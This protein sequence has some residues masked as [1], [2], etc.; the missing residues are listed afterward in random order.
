M[1]KLFSEEVEVTSTNSDHNTL[2]VER[3]EEVFFGVYEFEINNE[4]VIA[5]KVGEY[6]GNPVITVP[7]VEAD[8]NK[9]EAMFILKKGKQQVFYGKEQET[10]L[11]EEKVERPAGKPEI[12]LPSIFFVEDFEE[13][14]FGIYEF[15]LNGSK[16]IAEKIDTSEEGFP[17]VEVPVANGI[18]QVVLKKKQVVVEDKVKE[19]ET[20]LSE[21]FD[22]PTDN[23]FYVEEY[24]EI[25]FGVYEFELNN[26]KVLA[27]KIEEINGNP[28]VEVPVGDTKTKIVL[29][30]KVDTKNLKEDNTG[31]LNK[32]DIVNLEQYE[33]QDVV[34]EKTEADISKEEIVEKANKVKT[35]VKEELLQEFKA[36]SK[37]V[38]GQFRE[39][40]KHVVDEVER[41]RDQIFLEFASNSDNYRKDEAKKLRKFVNTRVEELREQNSGLAEKLVKNFRSNLEETYGS[42]IL[43]LRNT[44]TEL[45]A[46]K[47]EN[48]KLA[49][50][51]NVLEKAQLEINNDLATSKEEILKATKA[52]D[53]TVNEAL[54]RSEKNVNKALSRLGTVKKELSDSKDH[55]DTIKGD[56][57]DSI[58]QAEERVK[59]YYHEKIKMVEESVFRNIRR[60]EILDTVKK[61]K[62]MILAELNNTNGLKDQLRQLATEAANGE[63]DPITGKRFQ[64][65]LKKDLNN[66]FAKE[67]QNI[68]RMMEMY[69]GG[70][71]VAKQYANGGVMNG[72]LNVNGTILSGGVDIS[73]LFGVGS[74]D[75]GGGGGGTGEVGPGTPGTFSVFQTITSIEDG[76]LRQDGNEIIIDNGL[77]T[78]SSTDGSTTLSASDYGLHINSGID[79][80]GNS[81]VYGNLSVLGDFTYIDSTVSVTSALSVINTGTGPALYAEQS[82]VG[83]PI[84]KFVDSEGGQ[85][86]I[87]DGGNV[88]IGTANPAEKLTVIGN[89]SASGDLSASNVYGA[90]IA[91]LKNKQDALYSYL[92]QNFDTNTVTDATN[93]SDFVTN[94]PKTG[95][96]TGDVITISATNDA[97]ILGDNDGSALTD[98]LQ[99]N[100]KPNFLFYKTNVPDY[101]VLDLLPLSAAKS[102]KYIIEVE[103]K[104][105]GA[106][107]YGEVNV[108][109]DGTI[110]VATEYGLNHT[111]VFPFVEF[112]AEVVNGTHIQLSAI[113][114][115]GKSMGNFVFKGNRANLFG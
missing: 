75:G 38:I 20:L 71:T 92:I 93:I 57:A 35:E 70:G 69:S 89:V 29:K 31:Y 115:E 96:T 80:H 73:S 48:K 64:E 100:L 41:V 43:K 11:V 102:S 58:K 55:F 95:L 90:N 22:L 8:D 19:E 97:Y 50:H 111:T 103:D 72:D 6:E 53:A 47:L 113:A 25:Y 27:E 7:I 16:L 101:S 54:D 65:Q 44:Q 63:Y 26:K 61:S 62:A 81:T 66:K 98:W 23:T 114:L 108:V 30:K 85:T 68:R 46:R 74:S 51:V 18:A 21:D 15:E 40:T 88:G 78:L 42:F 12:E 82:G 76:N 36:D 52:T 91:T 84:A 67:M 99:V 105:D 32:N 49:A 56:L 77:F 86:I 83:E 1:I 112:G 24:D 17:V 104:S 14:H 28:V 33:G 4:T 110:A 34:V 39:E 9:T 45:K 60:E 2:F 3:F 94:Y 79:I 106:L 109:S 5:E 87:D 13:I 59:L 107:F 37:A 10:V